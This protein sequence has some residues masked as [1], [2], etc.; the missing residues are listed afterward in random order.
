MH[1]HE[2]E[3]ATQ[4][5]AG[6]GGVWFSGYDPAHANVP[7]VIHRFDSSSGM[8][9]VS[10]E[11]THGPSAMALGPRSLWIMNY[12]CSINRVDLTKGELDPPWPCRR[13]ATAPG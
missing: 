10:I 9:D 11:D 4:M 3:H 1:S 6:G 13:W 5:V 12:D 8:V 2:G 7:D